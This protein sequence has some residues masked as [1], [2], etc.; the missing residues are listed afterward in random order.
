VVTFQVAEGPGRRLA[1][2]VALTVPG[3]LEVRFAGSEKLRAL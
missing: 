3:V 2:S 1:E